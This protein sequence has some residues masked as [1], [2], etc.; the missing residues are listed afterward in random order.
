MDRPAAFCSVLLLGG[1]TAT[2]GGLFEI[3]RIQ[4]S[5]QIDLCF[6][7]ART[8]EHGVEVLQI[9]QPDDVTGK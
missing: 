1:S 9:L 6:E 8:D 3:A 5:A 2:G 7:V 4:H